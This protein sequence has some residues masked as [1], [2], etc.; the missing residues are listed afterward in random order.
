MGILVINPNP[1]FDRT[2]SL[3]ELVPGAVMRT[4]DVDLTAGGKGINVARVLRAL[5][6]AVRLI[7]PVGVDDRA[8]Y[9]SLLTAEG[10]EAQLIGV[11]GP[12]RMANIYLENLT[13]RV[14]VINDAGH[15][16]SGS[17]W[18]RVHSEI[19]ASVNS[20][21]L[22]LIMGSFPPGLDPKVLSSL[23]AAVHASGGHVLL[24]V[25]PE[26]LA[27]SL[28][29]GP[30]V[31][32]PNLDEAEAALADASATVMDSQLHEITETE[33]IRDRAMNAALELCARGAMHAFVTAGAAGVAM[34]HG[35][36]VLWMNSFPVDPISAVGAGDSFVAGL[37]HMW[38]Q[39]GDSVDWRAATAF[40]IAT[41]ASSCEQV[42]AGG[43]D[44][45]RVNEIFNTLSEVHCS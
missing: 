7:I 14:T 32:T 9:E 1:V 31:I 30:D 45:A 26:W 20:G 34:A 6:Q 37:A 40:G 28:A 4:L 41:S 43:V 18:D 35:D 13:N 16:M 29:A 24:D 17:D 33:K 23:I 42:R 38:N 3:T 44:T 39:A 10:A 2:I 36:E 11:S 21:D 8:R 15:P 19:V 27:M 22:V 5:D 12:V 25:N